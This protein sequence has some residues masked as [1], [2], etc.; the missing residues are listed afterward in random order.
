MPA[1]G[2]LDDPA[3]WPTSY[4]A[5]ERLFAT[6]TDVWRD[7]TSFRFRFGIPVIVALVETDVF[8]TARSSWPANRDRIKRRADHPLVVDVGAGQHKAN[9]YAATIGQYMALGAEFS[10]IGGIGTGEVPPFGAFT[11]ALSS[12]D[13]FQSMPRSSS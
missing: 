8:W 6:S 5:D 10:T 3:A 11:E 13:H 1:I 2:A 4:A 7:A 9:R 12:D